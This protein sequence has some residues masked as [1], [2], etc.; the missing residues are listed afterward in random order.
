M[1]LSV[2][3]KYHRLGPNSRLSH[4]TRF[5]VRPEA[6]DSE[7]S[8]VRYEQRPDGQKMFKMVRLRGASMQG[9]VSEFSSLAIAASCS[10]LCTS[11]E[12]SASMRARS[13]N[14]GR[15]SWGFPVQQAVSEI[16]T[17]TGG[18]LL[19]SSAH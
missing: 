4:G 7:R 5:P 9:T 15:E 19:G 16:T 13:T 8:D 14:L 3:P 17:R 6:Y 11:A 10:N 12:L 2:S 18:S 1:R